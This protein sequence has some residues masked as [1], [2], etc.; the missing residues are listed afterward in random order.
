MFSTLT[1]STAVFIVSVAGQAELLPTRASDGLDCIQ[2]AVTRASSS[3]VF[4][5]VGGEETY[6][7][8]W[9]HQRLKGFNCHFII[10]MLIYCNK[11]FKFK[12]TLE[13]CALLNIFITEL[14]KSPLGLI[15]H[16][17][18]RGVDVI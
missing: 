13:F 16:D 11:L 3:E 17:L 4:H 8:H 10:T 6:R 14:L 2:T 15:L 5:T 18:V 9:M 12:F 1:V 7:T